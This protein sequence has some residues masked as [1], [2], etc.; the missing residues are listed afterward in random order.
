[1]AS[2]IPAAKAWIRPTAYQIP[3]PNFQENP[4][5][6]LERGDWS[7]LF[8]EAKKGAAHGQMFRE[9][10]RLS[11]SGASEEF[12]VCAV[13]DVQITAQSAFSCRVPH[14]AL[15]QLFPARWRKQLRLRGTRRRSR[16]EPQGVPAD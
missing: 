8:V 16:A 7:L 11:G 5:A 1:M 2:K 15:T 13:C 6:I 9:A 4:P 10:D 12:A 14:L 3:W